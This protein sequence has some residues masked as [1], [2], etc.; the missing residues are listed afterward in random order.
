MYLS[1]KQLD[2]AVCHF[3]MEGQ[4][5]KQID[6]DLVMICHIVYGGQVNL[7]TQTSS[8]LLRLAAL[9]ARYPLDWTI[10]QI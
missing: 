6:D 1:R 3:V 10:R 8:S 9:A 5:V 7:T 2:Y 4:I